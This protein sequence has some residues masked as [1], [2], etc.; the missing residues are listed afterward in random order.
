VTDR[1]SLLKRRIQDQIRVITDDL[2]NAIPRD[3]DG[4]TELVR[5]LSPQHQ[6]K[7][8]SSLF[9]LSEFDKNSI[10]LKKR[11]EVADMSIP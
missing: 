2:R 5:M 3:Y 7:M 10:V 8:N 1:L 9:A 4:Y 6:D 11:I